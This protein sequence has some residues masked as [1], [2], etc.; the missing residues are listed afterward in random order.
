MDQ[1]MD[2]TTS[3]RLTGN[4]VR[5]RRYRAFHRRIDYVPTPDVWAIIDHHLKIG[6]DPCLAGVI[7]YLIRTGHQAITGNGG[8]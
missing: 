5:V 1:E 7:D 6:T 8:T 4:R 3:T 2:A